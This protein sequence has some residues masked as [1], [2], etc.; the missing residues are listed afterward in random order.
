MK[1]AYQ[2][3]HIVGAMQG[4]FLFLLLVLRKENKIANKLL[5]I[6]MLL[7]SIHLTTSFLH[8]NNDA[9]IDLP[10]IN[11][12]DAF[13]LAYGPLLLLYTLFLTGRREKLSLKQALPFLPALAMFALWA[14]CGIFGEDLHYGG[15]SRLWDETDPLILRFWFLFHFTS[16][17]HLFGYLTYSIL[18]IYRYNTKLK[19]YFSNMARIYLLWLSTLLVSI[20]VICLAAI[21]QF[22]LFSFGNTEGPLQWFISGTIVVLV[23]V[24]G[25]FTNRQPDILK[26]LQFMKA[27]PDFQAQKPLEAGNPAIPHAEAGNNPVGPVAE[28]TAEL[29]ENPSA[30]SKYERN[31]LG[32]EEEKAY[33]NRLLE[34]MEENRPYLEPELNLRQLSEAVG[35]P[36]HLLSM[37][38]SIYLDR[39]FYTFINEYRVREAKRRLSADPNK[40]HNI[41]TIAYDSGFNSKSTFNTVFRRFEGVTPSEYRSAPAPGKTVDA[42]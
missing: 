10:A 11:R 7:L 24:I 40:E 32:E 35:I 2:I 5:A 22:V 25:Y 16:L 15:Y 39:N 21:V 4:L 3:I 37:L 1:N 30:G 42:G 26:D 13:I 28:E 31:R 19:T 18:T 34:F 23:F 14:L 12:S 38:L 8:T 9:I 27:L 6:L 33:L 29:Q 17:I 36:S 41:L 20:T